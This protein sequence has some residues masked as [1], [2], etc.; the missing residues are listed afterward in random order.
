MRK[1]LVVVVAS[2]MF[3]AAQ[4]LGSEIHVSFSSEFTQQQKDCALAAVSE[5]QSAIRDS[6]TFANISMEIGTDISG[7]AGALV[8]Q[9]SAGGDINLTP[10]PWDSDVSVRIEVNRDYL[11]Q[12]FFDPCGAVPSNEF[13]GLTIFRH[14]L[15]HAVGFNDWYIAFSNHLTADSAGVRTYQ[16]Q[17]FILGITPESQGAHISDGRYSNDLMNA[18]VAPGVRRTISEMDLRVLSDAYGYQTPEPGTLAILSASLY[19]LIWKRRWNA[20]APRRSQD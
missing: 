12:I 17:D 14:E 20:G 2:L 5:W 9:S 1:G 11:S 4:A 6:V 10:M 3:L 8:A 13:D 16:G 19:G 15:S 7:L 18:G